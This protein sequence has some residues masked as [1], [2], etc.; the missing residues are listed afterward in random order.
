VLRDGIDHGAL[1][2][3]GEAPARIEVLSALWNA[4]P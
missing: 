4:P 3:A 1:V 2:L